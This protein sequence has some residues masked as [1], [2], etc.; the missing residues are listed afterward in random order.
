MPSTSAVISVISRWFALLVFAGVGETLAF[1]PMPPHQLYGVVRDAIGN[2]LA[3]GATVI[4]EAASSA[5]LTTFV[6]AQTD[7][8][9]NYR[10]EVPLDAGLA[11][12]SY[13]PTAL[14]PTAPF[15]L[16]VRIGKMTYLPMEMTGDVAHIG[17]AGGRTR[18]D[19][20]LGVDS[21]GNG[22]PDDWEKAVA[23]Q[24][25]RSWVSGQIR[26]ADPYPGTGMT[27][28][29]VYLS[30]TYAVAPQEG[31][32]LEILSP[33][34]ESPKLAFTA[35]KGRRYTVQASSS[36]GNWATVPFRL[37]A[38]DTTPP[39]NAYQATDTRRVEIEAPAIDDQPAKF[40]RLIVE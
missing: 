23:A 8:A 25:G 12:G 7:S 32:A 20:T 17:T 29:E 37:S 36:L 5:R 6:L 24:L 38:T 30:G 14:V 33:P 34:G 21:D 27:Y 39:V 22:L 31:F 1:P 35:V 28:Q 18:M 26:P 19:L 2:P 9:F 16:R 40:Y 13:Q 10:L 11:A 4:L 3:D 15:K